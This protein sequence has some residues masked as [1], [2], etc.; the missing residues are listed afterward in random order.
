DA[1]PPA[2]SRLPCPDPSLSPH[3]D[4]QYEKIFRLFRKRQKN[5]SHPFSRVYK[6]WP[7]CPE[8]RL[9]IFFNLRSRAGDDEPA[10]LGRPGD[11]AA[12][13]KPPMGITAVLAVDEDT[14]QAAA[15]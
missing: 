7:A 8:G 14:Y 6:V 1:I 5:L 12:E 4:C 10:G 13:V 15:P 11:A 9:S 2:Q 3:V